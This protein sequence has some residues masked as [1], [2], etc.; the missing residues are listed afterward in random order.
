MQQHLLGEDAEQIA[1]KFNAA[2]GLEPLAPADRA[3]GPVE[4][5]LLVAVRFH[6]QRRDPSGDD[7]AG[8]ARRVTR[9]PAVRERR[10][11][12]IEQPL[13]PPLP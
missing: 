5:A 2:S 13:D 7:R 9:C 1:G 8:D 11:V 4:D 3:A 12:A 6:Q 10:F